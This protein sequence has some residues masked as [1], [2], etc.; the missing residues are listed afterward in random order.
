MN[1]GEKYNRRQLYTQI[2]DSERTKLH[3]KTAAKTENERRENSP[4]IKQNEIEFQRGRDAEAWIVLTE[5][6]AVGNRGKDKTDQSPAE[7][8]NRYSAPVGR[9]VIHQ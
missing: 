3:S 8:K 2:S 5:S 9:Q 1:G 7:K 6:D 4:E